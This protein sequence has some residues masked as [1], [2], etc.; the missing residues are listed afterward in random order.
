VYLGGVGEGAVVG[1]VVCASD[2]PAIPIVKD[3][4][5]NPMRMGYA[6][7]ESIEV[8]LSIVASTSGIHAD[9]VHRK[10]RNTKSRTVS[11]VDANNE[12][13]AKLMLQPWQN[14]SCAGDL[15]SANGL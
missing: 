5:S 9:S 8:R 6:S 3:R 10:A 4:Q 11:Y 2:V 13:K 7:R 1:C 14:S 12:M 15:R